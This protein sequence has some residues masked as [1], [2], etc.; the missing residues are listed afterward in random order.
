MRALALFALAVV[1]FAAA[2]LEAAAQPL[3]LSRV[4]Y[5]SGPGARAI[6][7][8]DFN[9]DGWPDVAH[10]GLE[11]DKL[12]ILLNGRDGSL[13][14]RYTIQ[15]G[16]GPFDI[17]SADFNADGIT[18]LAVANA[19]SNTI[20]ILL[21]AGDGRFARVDVATA[22]HRSPRGIAAADIN[23]DGKVD[24]VYTAYLGGQV[25]V[26]LGNG[27]GGF[28]TWRVLEHAP[29]PQGAVI[30]DVNR[31]GR[32][33]IVVAHDGLEGLVLWR[34]SA[35]SFTP[36]VV[37]GRSNLN[38]VAT[39]DLDLDGWLD[40]A[41]A[42][43]DRGRVAIFGG[44]SSGLVYRRSYTVDSD[45]RGIAAADVNSD[46]LPDLVTASRSTSTV[47][48][49]LGNVSHPAS[50]LPRLT[51]V[52]AAGSRAVAIADL[53]VD[54]R[55]DVVVG[56]QYASAVSVLANTTPLGRAAYALARTTIPTTANL[57]RYR[58]GLL[59]GRG[60][61]AGDFNRDGRLD[62]VQR[63][64]TGNT[65]AVVLSSGK[66]VS[67][68][69][70]AAYGGHVVGDFNAD[71][72]A[73]VLSFGSDTAKSSR[74]HT[75][76]GDGG[77]TFRR[78][79][80]TSVDGVSF[81]SCVAGDL[82]RDARPD[83]ACVE[84]VEDFQQPG[85]LYLLLGRGDG[86]FVVPSAPTDARGMDPQLADI[87]RDGRLDVVLGMS[88]EIWYGNGAGGLT[89]GPVID[90][91][92]NPGWRV[93]VAELNRDG[94]PD[95]VY[96]YNGESMW[97]TLGSR[98][99]F[100]EMLPVPIGCECDFSFVVADFDVDGIADLLVNSVEGTELAGMMFVL[101]GRGDGTFGS[102]DGQ[103]GGADAFAFEPGEMLVADVTADGLPDALVPGPQAIHVL[104]NQRGE[105]NR[106]PVVTA[107]PVTRTIDYV[108]LM[109]DYAGCIS[110]PLTPPTDPDQHAP[111]VTWE[112]R[113]PQFSNAGINADGFLGALTSV[114]ACFE[115]PGTY[116]F[117]MHVRDDRGAEVSATFAE[118]NVVGPKE[119][120]LHMSDVG[121]SGPWSILSDPTAASGVRVYNVNAGLPKV[122]T[123]R[124]P[125]PDISLEFV[126]DP[127][128]AYK[129]W[130][131]LKAD[132]DSW[133]NDS[134]WV[135]F[136]WSADAA[137]APAYRIGTPSGLAVSLEECVNC[138]V[139]GW[140][141][142]DDGWGTMNRN[143]VLIRFP[144]GGRQQMI[145]QPR[146]DGVSIDQVVLSA[147]K[148]L[149]T[150]PGAAKNDATILSRTQ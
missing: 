67:L 39:A 124:W 25:A 76:L 129:L 146:E 122:T 35:T 62:F 77:G 34:Q 7:S 107:Q 19:D 40:V 13:T 79:P 31:D 137:G 87:N 109:K 121:A 72:R 117:L 24:L 150:P 138:G 30:A 85:R 59:A 15:V 60:F 48:V 53:D 105:T 57:S 126:A 8:G 75:H 108:T 28:T 114:T 95:I 143:G 141:W 2:S 125:A 12:S 136:A 139:A 1:L 66:T 142:Q 98:G 22:A 92:S 78:S 33:D 81:A 93:A 148:Y 120:V 83:L 41:A 69:V 145:I 90:L 37:P 134:V 118:V 55:I 70:P 103:F 49:L 106:P 147:E 20:S 4:D 17:A 88:G 119:I 45:P 71:G 128:M 149:T 65:V 51:F 29:R 113:Q 27:A 44:T 42:S 54:S 100:R 50:F 91:G 11:T 46:G 43:T 144:E 97:V 82:N 104:V 6:A 18:D 80:V 56:S 115:G 133:A 16:I 112:V 132:R 130:L 23:S 131:R 74:F 10:A 140:G 110:L 36:T 58:S 116:A 68:P 96:S 5:A 61:A 14:H 84:G 3:S 63:V 89:T 94:Y 9:R 127:A 21:G 64:A 86:T 135:Q 52:A 38:V 101:R 73:D 32:L 102:A 26:L 47:N 111:M 99:G 123:P